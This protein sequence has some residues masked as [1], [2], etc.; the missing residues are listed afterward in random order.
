MFNTRY[1][2]KAYNAP[3]LL[4]I[5]MYVTYEGLIIYPL[6]IQVLTYVATYITC[7]TTSKMI[8]YTVVLVLDWYLHVANLMI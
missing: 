3:A 1:I 4:Y 7:Y 8:V 6:H 5:A 2:H